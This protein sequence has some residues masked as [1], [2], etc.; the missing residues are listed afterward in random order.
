MTSLCTSCMKSLDERGITRA[1][2]PR[3]VLGGPEPLGASLLWS[4]QGRDVAP[5]QRLVAVPPHP[6]NGV[7]LGTIGGQAHQAPV[8]G[9]AQ[10]L[11]GM[12]PAVIEAQASETRGARLGPRV[13]AARNQ[14]RRQRRQCQTEPRFGE[15]CHG[16]RDGAPGEAVWEGTARLEAPRREAPAAHRQDADPAVVLAEPP[17]G[18]TMGRRDRLLELGLTGRLE[19]RNGRRGF[20]CAWAAPLSAWP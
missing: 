20:G 10:A 6:G 14:R 11:G 13:T 3:R 9:A 8:R 7:E 5:G 19:G 18:T 12:G 15:R 16:A 4:L 1:R 17:Q 2:V